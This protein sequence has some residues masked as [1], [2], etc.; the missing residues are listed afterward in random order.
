MK[1]TKKKTLNPDKKL[2]AACGLF[3][4]ACIIFIASRE[5]PEKREKLSR[6]LNIPLEMLQCDGCHSD[7]R[8]FYCLTCKLIACAN[9]R[10]VDFCGA[11]PDFPCNDLKEFQAAKPHRLELWQAHKRIQ[12]AGYEKWFAEML[13]HYACP[14]CGAL[15]SAY[16]ISCRE[17]SV[18][19]GNAFVEAHKTIISEHL[20]NRSK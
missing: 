3:C 6:R 18:T 15:N 16:H 7:K 13:E 4:P 12:E 19:P 10:G 5:T 20:A 11:C 17:C 8:F 2:T 1:S 14:S 9:Q